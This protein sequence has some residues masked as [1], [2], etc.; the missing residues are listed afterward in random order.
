MIAYRETIP[1]NSVEPARDVIVFETEAEFLARIAPKLERARLY[2][3]GESPEDEISNA[4]A[5]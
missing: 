2:L 4:A 5:R 3:Y 1:A